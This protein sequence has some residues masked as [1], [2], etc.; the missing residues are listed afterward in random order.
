M[1]GLLLTATPALADELEADDA[2]T[3]TP[4][5]ADIVVTARRR[6]ERLQDVP[7]AVTAL[8]ADKLDLAGVFNLN[9]SVQLL[10]SVNF[11]ASN[12]RN[13][14]IIIRGLGAPFGLTNDG[15]EQGVGLFIDGVYYSRPAAASF[16]FVDIERIEVLR[17]PQGT[18][19][20][21]NTTAG[22]VNITTCAPSFTPEGRVEATIGNLGFQQLRGSVSGPLTDRLALRAA[23]SYTSREGTLRNVRTGADSNQ[24]DNLGFRASLLWK[25][26]DRVTVTLAADDNRQN[27]DC[28]AQVYVRVAPTR[29][30]ANRQFAALAAASGYAP[31]SLDPFDRLIDN[32]S[33]LEARQYFGGASATLA[34]D[35]GAGTL[36]AITAWRYWNWYPSNDRDFTA[37][38]ITTISANFSRQRQYTQELR[39]TSSGNGPLTLVAGLFA[40]RQTIRNDPVQEQGR[41]A[42]LW[43]LGPGTDPAL[44]DGLRQTVRV[45]YTNDSLAGFGQL[46][47]QLSPRLK[48]QG[49]LRLNW[50]RKDADYAATVTGGL[51]TNDPVLIARKN[52]ILAA[53]AYQARFSDFNVSGD[54]TASYELADDVL[55]YAT[56]ARSF[57]PGGVNL[58]GLP[59]DAAGAPLLGATTVRP[60]R[61][62][63]YE[64]GLKSQFFSRSVTLNFAAFRTDIAD[65]QTNVVNAQIGVLRGYLANAA[66]VRVQGVEAEVSARLSDVIDVRLSG[67]YLDGTYRRFPDA[68]APLE[69]TGGPQVVDISGQRL[70]GVSRWTGA[71]SLNLHPPLAL[72]GAPGRVQA[73]L[74]V[75]ARSG[76]SSSPTPSAYLNVAGYALV[77]AQLG[78]QSDSGFSVSAWVRNAF[79]RNYF[80][81]LSAAPGGS[82]LVVGQPGDPRTFGVT[83]GKRF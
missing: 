35:L 61:I 52:S 53:Q 54:A 44:L 26:S 16:D 18:L 76:F 29:R 79:D 27:P 25:A 49:G 45:D 65:Y 28:C 68:P 77:N 8:Q 38:P 58:G 13:A 11:Y 60:E 31:P 6:T 43:L 22:S 34:V 67:T 2:A 9:R 41:A 1:S 19:Y 70:P 64:I 24:L 48:L 71:A 83:L 66:A 37:L 23:V 42:A 20:G 74:D 57:K 33:P 17:G 7:V 10:P 51:A 78:W 55:A 82:G 21:K 39:W 47:W 3:A 72:F 69:L 59:T 15:I 46:Q 32:D 81:F 80:D 12:P 62:N 40:Y 63:H 30:A 56:Y 4:A 14:A 36:T 75:Y 73:G 50:D 5:D